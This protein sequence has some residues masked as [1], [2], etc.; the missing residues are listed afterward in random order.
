VII[1]PRRDDDLD[2][3]VEALRLVHDSDAYPLNWPHD[4]RAWLAPAD[5][6][7]VAEAADGTIAGHV[8]VRE[9]ELCRLF[10]VPGEHR[11]TAVSRS[12][13]D[14]AKAWAAERGSVLTLNVVDEK[15]SAAIAFYE[16]TGWHF[17]HFSDA[18]WSGPDGRPVRL[19]HYK[20]G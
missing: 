10:V 1:R 4:P 17:T 13:V 19:R 18:D 7:W 12:L 3:C 6:A 11:G 2:R 8:A 15:R 14:Q 20:S 9:N 5:A 16:A